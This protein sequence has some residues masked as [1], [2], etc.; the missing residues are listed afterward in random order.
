MVKDSQIISP[1]LYPH[2]W[3]D[4]EG[5][6]LIK[7]LSGPRGEGVSWVFDNKFDSFVRIVGHDGVAV[8]IY[9]HRELSAWLAE[10][11]PS[12]L[13]Y[14]FSPYCPVISLR[15]LDEEFSVVEWQNMVRIRHTDIMVRDLFRVNAID[16]WLWALSTWDIPLQYMEDWLDGEEMILSRIER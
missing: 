12:S 1:F 14:G 16:E 13:H 2:D 8:P 3:S 9:R 7:R 11:H 4:D 6:D 5:R 10:P 15:K